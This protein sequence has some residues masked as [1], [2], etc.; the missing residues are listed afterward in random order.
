MSLS[1]ILS[2]ANTHIRTQLSLNAN[3]CDVMPSGQPP[4]AAGDLFI[5]VHAS[6]WSNGGLIQDGLMETFGITCTISKR[7]PK[8]PPVKQAGSIFLDAA[9]GIEKYARL[10]MINLHLSYTLLTAAN[11]LLLGSDL[12]VEPLRWVQ[13][14][15]TPRTVDGSWFWAKPDAMAG[16][17]L[18]V[19][20]AGALRP[21][22]STRWE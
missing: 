21:Q 16:L 4:P 1:S 6:E 19:I 9:A 2:A 15:P 5:A 3:Q 14:D 8:Y 7:A 22:D 20:F 18:D 12:T 10:L 17:V 11:Q 13:N